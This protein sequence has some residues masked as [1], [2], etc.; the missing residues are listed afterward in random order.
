VPGYA[1]CRATPTNV[2]ITRDIV[3]ASNPMSIRSVIVAMERD[4]YVRMIRCVDR[5]HALRVGA[6]LIDQLIAAGP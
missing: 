4:Y 2:G 5:I 1:P 3:T 6:R